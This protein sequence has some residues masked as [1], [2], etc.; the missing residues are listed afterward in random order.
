MLLLYQLI[1][2]YKCQC[3]I[4]TTIFILS[5]KKRYYLYYLLIMSNIYFI[6]IEL[7]EYI[8]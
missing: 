4:W 5:Y 7:I 6:T 8:I 1:A 2:Y 3:F